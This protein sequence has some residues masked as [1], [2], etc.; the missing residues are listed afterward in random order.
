MSPSVA[1]VKSRG[2]TSDGGSRRYHSCHFA[3]GPDHIIRGAVELKK[4]EAAPWVES[5]ARVGFV[6]KGL[7]Y[8]TIGVLAGCAGLGRGGDTTDTR[9]AMASLV[10]A[11]F[12][13]TLL[14]LIAI[15]LIGYSVWRFV[16]AITDPDRRGN[17]AK[18][19]A[20]RTGFFIRAGVH[21]WLA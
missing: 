3:V 16:E 10:S 20:M 12:G 8:A 21:L 7:L 4:S 19:L 13:R 11:P 15:G 1:S 9:G 17:D 5:L 14:I 18:G 6:A 2:L